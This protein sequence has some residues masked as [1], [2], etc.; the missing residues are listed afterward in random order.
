[1]NE[2]AFYD[3]SSERVSAGRCEGRSV[4]LVRAIQS[5]LK[6]FQFQSK[7]NLANGAQVKRK[8]RIRHKFATCCFHKL[9][10]SFASLSACPLFLLLRRLIV[11]PCHI[12]LKILEESNV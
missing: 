4:P 6:R 3:V 9:G 5:A 10:E 7:T 2:L 12:P 1:M 8:R 11:P